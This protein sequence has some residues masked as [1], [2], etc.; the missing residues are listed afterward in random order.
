MEVD[1]PAV[2]VAGDGAQARGKAK[3]DRSRGPSLVASPFAAPL[4]PSGPAGAA[5][6]QAPRLPPCVG[7]VASAE[8]LLDITERD[9]RGLRQMLGAGWA[10]P[11]AEEAG[12]HVA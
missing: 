12:Q 6:G 3:R 10:A 9:T 2:A 8:E 4:A 11:D 5:A 1:P 7:S